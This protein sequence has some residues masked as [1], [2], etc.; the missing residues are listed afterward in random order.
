[1]ILAL[2][3]CFNAFGQTANAQDWT[4]E[5]QTLRRG[6]PAPEN[7]FFLTVEGMEWLASD[8]EG[9]RLAS[10]EMRRD[11]EALRLTISEHQ[12]RIDT[13]S[14][15]NDNLLIWNA[16][17]SQQLRESEAF[18]LEMAATVRKR[19]WLGAGI[20]FLVGFTPF[21]IVLLK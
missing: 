15:D 10:E 1:M 12:R 7:G 9:Y 6:T 16:D 3:I 2:T 14:A 21:V 4:Q 11:L 20:G 19:F 8:V 17:L 5:I 13:L 18:S